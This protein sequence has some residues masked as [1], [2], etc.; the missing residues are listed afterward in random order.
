LRKKY[1]DGKDKI[2]PFVFIVLAILSII[3][4]LY[5]ILKLLWYP[6]KKKNSN[7]KVV[8]FVGI[9][10]MVSGFFLIIY[11]AYS[12]KPTITGINKGS[13]VK[14]VSGKTVNIRDTASI[15]GKILGTAKKG[16]FFHAVDSTGDWYRII[17][18]R[19]RTIDTANINKNYCQISNTT[20]FENAMK[21]KHAILFFSLMLFGLIMYVCGI[22]IKSNRK[23]ILT[24]PISEDSN[25]IL[26]QSDH[27]K[28]ETD[29]PTSVRMT[30]PPPDTVSELKKVEVRHIIDGDTVVVLKDWTEIRIR[31]DSIDCPED[32]QPWGNIAKAGLIKLIWGRSVYIEKHGLD[33]YGRTM[34]TIFL[35]IRDD[36]G[37]V[38]MNVNERMVM[39]GHAWV[40]RQYYNHL[41]KKRR[42]Q[43]DKLESWAI[44]KRVGLWKTNNPIPP[45]R[46]RN[47]A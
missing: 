10:C 24:L 41:P 19:E 31:L 30:P 3:G 26:S 25:I 36:Y 22:A 38:W 44:S 4:I 33:D 43:L 39:L 5:L 9:A 47:E 13:I 28:S 40:M 29:K 35:R 11:S 1:N 34:A 27:S 18:I 16:D 42:D 45:W 21:Y 14:V 37:P 32:G 20:Y 2:I 12:G 15:N 6:Y 8:G 7:I 23:N 17:Y 46:W